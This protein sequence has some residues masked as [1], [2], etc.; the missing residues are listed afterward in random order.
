M[1]REQVDIM[2]QESIEFAEMQTVEDLMNGK[3]HYSPSEYLRLLNMLNYIEEHLQ[4]TLKFVSELDAEEIQCRR[5]I[6]RNHLVL[7][8]S[9]LEFYDYHLAHCKMTYDE[10]HI[11]RQAIQTF[12]RLKELQ[13][14][15]EFI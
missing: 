10:L 7:V 6:L 14:E 13:Q 11:R 4:F 3:I 8:K 15:V 12:N 1:A 5:V 2:I 9:E